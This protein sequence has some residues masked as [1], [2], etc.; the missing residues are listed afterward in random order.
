ML[1]GELVKGSIDINAILES[2]NYN[3]D[4]ERTNMIDM[5]LPPVGRGYQGRILALKNDPTKVAKLIKIKNCTLSKETKEVVYLH[6]YASEINIGP[7]I[8]GTPFITTDC[9]HVV[10]IMDKI[11]PYKPLPQDNDEVIELFTKSFQHHFVPFDFE[12]AKNADGKLIFLDFGVCGLYSS[13][14]EAIQKAIDNDVFLYKDFLT[15]HFLNE[16]STGGTKRKK[17]RAKSLRKA[18]RKTRAKKGR[19]RTF[20]R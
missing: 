12:Y 1:G 14:K 16:L 2:T 19:R 9:S 17:S 10:F 4:E 18:R 7:K 20:K 15:T 6:V 3:I 11:V 8:Y 13:Y 5:T